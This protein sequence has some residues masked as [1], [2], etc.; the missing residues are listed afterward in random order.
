MRIRHS[1]LLLALFAGTALAQDVKLPSL[2]HL[3]ESDTFR[4]ARLTPSEKEQVFEEVAGIGFDTPDS[5]ESELRVRRIILGG[6][7]EGLVLQGTTLLCGGTGNCETFV[8]RRVNS[9]WIAMFDGQAPVASGFG[10]AQ[11]SS[12]GLKNFVIAANQSAE[13]E[14]YAVYKFD[15]KLYRA[16]QCYEKSKAQT[17]TVSCR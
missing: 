17:K 1:L 7:E 15:G 4:A 5:W 16:S 11:E 3:E 9:K 6:I 14:K 8:L 2:T 13:S 10:F 12:N